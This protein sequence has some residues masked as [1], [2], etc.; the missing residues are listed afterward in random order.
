MA[1]CADKGHLTVTVQTSGLCPDCG[2]KL[3]DMAEAVM[4]QLVNLWM[5]QHGGHIESSVNVTPDGE[6]MH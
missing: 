6:M 1:V 2:N 3:A 5:E 4:Q